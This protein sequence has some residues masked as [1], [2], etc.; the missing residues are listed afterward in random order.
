[1]KK[2]EFDELQMY[3]G[4]PYLIDCESTQGT[5]TIYEPTIGDIIKL[6]QNRFFATLN[7]FITNP[8]ANRLLLWNAG[9]DWNTISDFQLFCTLYKNI[10]PEVS[11]LLFGDLDWSKFELYSKKYTDS[12]EQKEEVVLANIEQNIEINEEVYEYIHQYLQKMFNMKPEVE[13]T[14]DKLLKDWWIRKDTIALQQKLKKGDKEEY[15]LKSMVSACVNHPGF[16]YKRNEL[17]EVGV[18]EFYDSVQRLQVYEQA[19]ACMKGLYS[20]FVDAKKIKPEA[21]NF[22]KNI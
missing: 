18:C 13:L 15:S 4:E 6:G 12:E 20:G 16:K 3:F 14:D 21:Y 17:R 19:T 1:M 7:V 5:I 10:D 8:T 22:M 11:S 2:I 9:I